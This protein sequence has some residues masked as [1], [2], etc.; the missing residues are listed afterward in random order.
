[1]ERI[2]IEQLVAN[3]ALELP[4][5]LE[6]RLTKIMAEAGVPGVSYAFFD[7]KGIIRS[8]ALGVKSVETQET[9]DEQ[10]VF[11]AGSLGK[12]VFAYAVLKMVERGILDLDRPLYLYGPHPGLQHDERHK[13]ITTR[14]VLSHTTGLPNIG[15]AQLNFV[16]DPGEKLLYSGEGYFYLMRVI[17][18]ITERSINEWME[19]LVFEPLGMTHTSYVWQDRF[20]GQYALSHDAIDRILPRYK[21]DYPNV[22][23]SMQTT[24]QDYSRLLSALLREKD[25]P[26][27][28]GEG[29]LEP[30]VVDVRSPQDESLNYWGLGIGILRTESQDYY[31]QWGVHNWSSSLFMISAKTG[32]GMVFFTN[33]INGFG[34]GKRLA[35]LCFEQHDISDFWLDV[36]SYEA[37][38]QKL[39]LSLLRERNFDKAIEPLLN[40]E[41]THHNT[42]I[43]NEEQIDVIG[44]WLE[45]YGLPWL[46][47]RVFELNA[48][49][50]PE[51]ADAQE[52]YARACLFCR[53]QSEAIKHFEKTLAIDPSRGMVRQNYLQLKGN[54]KGNVTFRLDGHYNANYLAVAGDFNGWNM[55]AHPFRRINGE[56]VCHL[57]IEPGTYQYKFVVDGIWVLDPNNPKSS[58]SGEH[59]SI[60][61]VPKA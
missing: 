17:E 26:G 3:E 30:F 38:Q 18:D 11:C 36:Y 6:S 51:S 12:P 43:L 13:L 57:N 47:C 8:G 16:H 42:A 34:L 31:W 15:G 1:M 22:A 61:E 28:I 50:Y 46:A 25:Q 40:E 27:L 10:T 33:S 21:P 54:V 35:N 53:K 20:E 44:T 39:L 56:W 4:Q 9:F 55:H 60:L 29:M 52:N 37:P 32:R 59:N 19:E 24:A 49:A 45:Q 7:A 23:Y 14:M 41:R 48:K 5:D 2:N 58:H